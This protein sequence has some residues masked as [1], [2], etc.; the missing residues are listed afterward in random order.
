MDE[1]FY[2]AMMAQI[3]RMTAQQAERFLIALNSKNSKK[4]SKNSNN[5]NSTVKDR[6]KWITLSEAAAKAKVSVGTIN[7][8]I[9]EK[10]I[11]TFKLRKK[12]A[13][14]TRLVTCINVDS[15]D[16]I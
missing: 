13:N 7:N 14:G 6:K 1:N 15:L 16:L 9:R 10:D 12:L 5:N 2:S 4:S 11:T 8:R 3:E